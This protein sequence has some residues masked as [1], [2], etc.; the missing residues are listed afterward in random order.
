MI[1]IPKDVALENTS[2]MEASPGERNP[3]DLVFIT[4]SE[5]FLILNPSLIKLGTQ[6]SVLRAKHSLFK[7]LEMSAIGPLNSLKKMVEKLLQLLNIIQPF[8]RQM[9]LT[10]RMLN[11]ISLNT[12]LSKVT[13][14]EQMSLRPKISYQCLKTNVTI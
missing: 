3:Q 14:M 13:N 6:S 2:V 7:A 11:N 4:L 5:N 8:T 1:L 10:L 9:V 12:V